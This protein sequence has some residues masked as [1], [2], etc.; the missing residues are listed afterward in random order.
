MNERWKQPSGMTIDPRDVIGDIADDEARS[1]DLPHVLHVVDP[2]LTTGCVFGPF[3]T[4]IDAACFAE[5][6]VAEL[7][8]A[9]CLLPVRF[10]IYPLRE[11]H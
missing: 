8:Y 6:Y 9:G 10:T 5:Q 1:L 4:P 11:G 7:S 2:Y 3:S